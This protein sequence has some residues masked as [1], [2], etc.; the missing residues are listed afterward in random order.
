MFYIQSGAYIHVVSTAS[1]YV[2][3]SMRCGPKGA[4]TLDTCCHIKPDVH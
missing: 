1:L 3:R 2:E 4:C